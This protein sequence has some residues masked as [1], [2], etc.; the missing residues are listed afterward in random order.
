MK[1]CVIG[2]GVIGLSSALRILERFPED[3]V[4]I[5][6]DRFSPNT[7]CDGAAGFW[8]PYKV[9]NTPTSLCLKWSSS[10][11]EHL[12]NISKSDVGNEAGVDLTSGYKFFSEYTEAPFWK[13]TCLGFRHV[14]QRE[15][16]LFAPHA[17]DGWFFISLHCC[18]E[19][20]LPWLLKQLR[21][22][23]CKLV[24]RK[25]EN[26]LE[27]ATYFDVIVN[28]TGLGSYFLVKDNDLISYQGQLVTVKNVRQNLFW[29]DSYGPYTTSVHPREEYVIAGTTVYPGKWQ[30]EPSLAI[31]DEIL[32]RA[33]KLVPNLRNGTVVKSWTGLRPFRSKGVRLEREVMTW[34]SRKV[35]V[36]H[37][38]G[39]GGG[40]ITLHWGCAG[41]V[42]NLVG[43]CKHQLLQSKL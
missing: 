14:T 1:I 3:E 37:N 9:G 17:K 38:Y 20:Y 8:M 2:A 21:R 34:R 11:F 23:N 27:L 19:K 6:A 18:C 39:H 43:E 16:D 13:D 5:F 12:L 7:T 25:L 29:I 42:A 15:I 4:T 40:G 10:T 41:N 26:L 22:K 33:N 24:E 28:C 36:I 31:Q 30:T 32:K 35:H